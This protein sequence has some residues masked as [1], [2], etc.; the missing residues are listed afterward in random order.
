VSLESKLPFSAH[1][2]SKCCEIE[3]E[4]VLMAIFEP[5]ARRSAQR[6]AFC[7]GRRA[8]AIYTLIA[9][10]KL[11]DVDPQAWLADVLGRLPDHPAKG[12]HELLPWNWHPQNVAHAA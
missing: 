6:R 9:S 10:A 12:I 5:T 3:T 4:I 2:L 8:A 11:N 7:G 1:E